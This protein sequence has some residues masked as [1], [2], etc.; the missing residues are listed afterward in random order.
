M[1]SQEPPF[2]PLTENDASPKFTVQRVSA[3]TVKDIITGMPNNKAPGYE[4]IG[5]NA[6]KACLPHIL[7]VITE[8]FN[9]FLTSGC[10]P[11]D[12]KIAEVVS[13]PKDGDREEPSN[14]R[15]ISLLPVLS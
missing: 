7:D 14:N 10:F 5:I 6:I 1:T 3:D 2:C 13:H 12:W 15:P 8:I 4:K 11:K 9:N